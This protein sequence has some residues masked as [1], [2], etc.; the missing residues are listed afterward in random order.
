MVS[1]SA[2]G[3]RIESVALMTGSALT[4]VIVTGGTSAK[5]MRSAPEPAGQPL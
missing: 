3:P 4:I 1:A 2:P 5:T